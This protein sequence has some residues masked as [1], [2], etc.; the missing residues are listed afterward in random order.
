MFNCQE[1]KKRKLVR[2]VFFK[3]VISFFIFIHTFRIL[4][5][6][7]Q[8]L[9]ISYK[10]YFSRFKVEFIASRCSNAFTRSWNS[11]KKPSS[12]FTDTS[13][14]RNNTDISYQRFINDIISVGH[15]SPSFTPSIQH[16]FYVEHQ[17]ADFSFKCVRIV[18]RSNGNSVKI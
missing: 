1:E 14:G 6:V 4:C 8:A 16:A 12:A 2:L 11:F 9:T 18:T 5:S 3:K 13:F 7:D 17:F 15:S 10:F